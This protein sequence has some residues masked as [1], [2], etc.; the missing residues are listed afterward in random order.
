MKKDT[1]QIKINERQM[2]DIRNVKYG[3]NKIKTLWI[4]HNS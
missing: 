1:K 2:K 3:F 4:Y